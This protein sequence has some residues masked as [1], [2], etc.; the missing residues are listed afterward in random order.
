MMSSIFRQ[1]LRQPSLRTGTASYSIKKTDSDI[2]ID[3]D[4]KKLNVS[5]YIVKDEETE[6]REA[7]IAKIRNKSGLLS[8]DHRR[9]KNQVPYDEPQSWVHL[10]VAYQRK[11]YGRYGAVSGVDPRIM[12]PTAEDLADKAEYERVAFPKTLQQ[13]IAEEKEAAELKVASK[14]AREEDI[15]KKLTKLDQWT[16]ELRARVAKKEADARAAEEKRE[17]LVEDVRRQ[18]GFRLDARDPRFA[19]MLEQ[20]E[21]EDKKVS[22]AMKKQKK[23]EIVLKRLQAQFENTEELKRSEEIPE[24]TNTGGDKAKKSKK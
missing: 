6:N 18:F 12:F 24:P 4:D 23:Q 3:E 8:Q 14:R 5:D 19:E 1:L 16:K 9:V 15:A 22:K 13:M 2:Y 11:M 17:R 10:T 7:Y 20:K 21:L